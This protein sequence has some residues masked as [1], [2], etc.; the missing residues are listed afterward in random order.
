MSN[1]ALQVIHELIYNRYYFWSDICTAPSVPTRIS[2]I[3]SNSN[4]LHVSAHRIN[5]EV[6]HALSKQVLLATTADRRIHFFDPDQDFSLLRSIGHLQDSPILSCNRLN[7][8]SLTTITSGMSG[9][10]LLYDYENDQVLEERRDH[11]KYIVDIAI[12]DEGPITW[13]ATAGWD[14]QVFLYQVCGTRGIRLGDPVASLSTLTNP[15]SITFIKYPDLER[16][17]LLVTRR[18]STSLYYYGLPS[19]DQ[20]RAPMCLLGSQNLAPHSNAWIAFSP[21]SI[22]VSPR[23]PTLLAVVSSFSGSSHLQ[24]P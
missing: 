8:E 7:G 3:P 18:D 1:G 5:S 13:V 11:K 6:P 19:V 15:E 12:C 10:T 14:S 17:V 9:Q 21:S 16:P 2:S 4:V 20:S 22:A 24:L 23:D